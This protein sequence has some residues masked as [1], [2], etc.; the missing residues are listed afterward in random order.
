MMKRAKVVVWA[1]VLCAIIVGLLTLF[2]PTPPSAQ[3]GPFHSSLLQA[4][5]TTVVQFGAAS[6][7]I[8][9]LRGFKHELRVA[10][11]II[12]V[13]VV[14]LGLSNLQLPIVT[15][16][17]LAHSAYVTYGIIVIPYI[18]PTLLVFFG[19]RLFAR[20]FHLKT[21][22]MSF[23]FVM[24]L[25]TACAV[26]AVGLGKVVAVASGKDFSANIA[27]SAWTAIFLL[28]SLLIVISIKRI[29]GP[30]YRDA[31]R[32]FI[33]A[34]VV[35]T[36][37]GLSYTLVLIFF[38]DQNSFFSYGVVLTPSAISAFL[39]L[40][41]GYAFKLINEDQVTPLAAPAGRTVTIID[42]I[43]FA[44]SQASNPSELDTMLDTLRVVTSTSDANTGTHQLTAEQ[45]ESL[46]RLYAD[47]E[48]YLVE[49]EPIRRLTAEEIRRK[50]ASYLGT[51]YGAFVA[52][53]TTRTFSQQP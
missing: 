52:L 28:A 13:G 15:Y 32:W 14:M 37:T 9:G 23:W 30:L 18:A 44:A 39:F 1:T 47:I 43:T 45:Q 16:F 19:V 31:L 42:A 33:A 50:G 11:G 21:I 17:S 49:K 46:R 8:W 29:A 40:R 24:A 6:L 7:F 22:W 41:A 20:L 10:Y 2:I 3:A 25:G 36:L 4:V 38:G 27:V 35:V 34:R 53:V 5:V 48:R 51:D 26:G 12:C